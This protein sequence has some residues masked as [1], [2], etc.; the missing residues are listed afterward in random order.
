MVL[1]KIKDF[2]PSY[3]DAFGGYDIKGM[4]VYSDI[5]NEKIGDVHDL[6]VDEQ[7]Y[8]RYFIVDLGFWAFGKKVLLPVERTQADSEGKHLY[9]IGFTKDQ[10]ENL[11]EFNESLKIDDGD[12]N[13]ARGVHQ[14]SV[15]PTTP[16]ITQMPPVRPIEQSPPLGQTTSASSIPPTVPQPGYTAPPPPVQGYSAQ[17]QPSQP[18]PAPPP[19][20][21]ML[22]QGQVNYPANDPRVQYGNQPSSM[23]QRANGQ[24][25]SI[26]QRFEERLR[27][28]HQ[29]DHRL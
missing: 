19:V 7:G 14:P 18:Y 10:I 16:P 17:T 6:M 13:L 11:P 5:N 21:P 12:R 1:L 15:P 22:A 26:L 8:F 4:N 27:T 3:R 28:K 24:S 20:D 9:A 29:H 2:D 23:P 25:S